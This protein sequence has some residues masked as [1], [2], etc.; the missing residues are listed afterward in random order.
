MLRVRSLGT[1]PYH[2]AYA[3]Q[4][5]LASEAADDYLLVLQHPHTYTLGAHAE[6]RHVLVDPALVG[7]VL[8]R[9]DRGGDVTYHGPG[10][11]VAYPIVT[12]DDVPASGPE[13]VHRLEQVVMATLA[14]LGLDGASVEDEYPGVWLD[15][16]RSAPA[17]SPRSGCGRCAP[18][19]GDVGRSTGSPST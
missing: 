16:G 18:A 19:R 7:A 5:A 13:H 4:H 10:Q 14:D 1:V 3:L 2:E 9:T 17:R 6:E 11:L 12:V 8:E 15:A